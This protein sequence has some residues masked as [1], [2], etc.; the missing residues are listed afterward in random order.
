MDL[1]R[2]IVGPIQTEKS[3]RAKEARTYTLRIHPHATKVDVRGAIKH[4]YGIEVKSVRVMRV[5]PKYRAIGAGRSITKRHGAKKALI[6][7]A[8]KSKPIDFAKFA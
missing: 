1:K 3:E 5:R 2:V 8:A 4:F 7:L 6:T